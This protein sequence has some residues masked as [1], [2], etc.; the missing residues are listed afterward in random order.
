M[1]LYNGKKQ[2]NL[3]Y[4]GI[5]KYVPNRRL[6]GVVAYHSDITFAT[7]DVTTA[8]S[9]RLKNIFRCKEP[10][11]LYECNFFGVLW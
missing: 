2:G 11:M 9:I 8:M 7:A 1:F 3:R 5:G 6:T 10:D 4:R